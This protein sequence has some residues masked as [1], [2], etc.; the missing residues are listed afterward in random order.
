VLIHASE[1]RL[2]R[3]TRLLTCV[4]C[5]RADDSDAP[6]PLGMRGNV[7]VFGFVPCEWEVSR[8]LIKM[9]PE[10]NVCIQRVVFSLWPTG[11]DFSW[12][13]GDVWRQRFATPKA[14]LLHLQVAVN[15]RSDPCLAYTRIHAEM[16]THSR[17]SS[18][19]DHST[20]GR[21]VVWVQACFHA[22][23][24]LVFTQHVISFSRN[25]SSR[26]HATRHLAHT[27]CAL[28]WTS[29]QSRT[30]ARTRRAS[31]ACAIPSSSSFCAKILCPSIR[32]AC[33][34]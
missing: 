29:Q 10:N 5:R 4:H 26:F 7:V 15:E 11:R 1:G 14:A 22:T 6:L 25:T 18:V 12:F 8:A 33:R 9:D 27:G 19:N 20:H 13:K 24:H 31:L 16:V 17:S 30:W 28:A 3:G 21:H 23:R 2:D 34:R 32:R